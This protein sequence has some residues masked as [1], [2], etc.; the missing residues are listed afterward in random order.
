MIPELRLGN[1]LAGL[2]PL[3]KAAQAG[4]VE[5]SLEDRI[6]Y[7]PQR[8]ILACTS[9][10][11]PA[12]PRAG[13]RIYETDTQRELIWNGTSWVRMGGTINTA[14][15][16]F[17]IRRNTNQSIASGA[18][19]L[20]SFDLEDFDSDGYITVTSTTVTIPA[21]L[22]GVYG[23]T[24]RVQASAGMS[25]GGTASIRINGVADFPFFATAGNGLMAAS[26]VHEIA[27][28]GTLELVVYNGHSGSLNFTAT[29]RAFR[30]QV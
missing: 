3:D 29:F 14:R 13:D 28:A 23:I 5:R 12:N 4:D 15:S 20:I 6:N 26:I 27:A 11:R 25:G 16:G 7:A 19:N 9:T 21:G 10:T 30:L 22:G 2:F 18:T 24:A 1:R 8:Y 17:I